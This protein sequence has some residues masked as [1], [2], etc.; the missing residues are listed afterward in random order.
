MLIVPKKHIAGL[1]E[2]GGGGCGDFGARY[3]GKSRFRRG[4][5]RISDRFE[6]GAG[7][8]VD[9]ICMHLLGGG[10]A[11]ASGIRWVKD[12]FDST[13]AAGLGFAVGVI[14]VH[15]GV[16]YL[17]L[18]RTPVFVK[19]SSAALGQRAGRKCDLL[20]VRAA[21]ET[22]QENSVAVSGESGSSAGKSPTVRYVWE[23][24]MGRL[25][26]RGYGAPTL[27]L[28]FPDPASFPW[29]VPNGL[30]GDVIVEVTI[31]EQG[32]VTETRLL[33]S[34]K[35]DIDEKVV[36]TVRN[37]RFRPATVDGVA[38]SSRQDVHFHYPG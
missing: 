30:T 24:S 37:W 25:A 31:D 35:H 5:E 3:P 13:T 15:C 34:L 17:W 8:G 29:Q 38:I 27:P 7:A 1:K 16:A 10:L 12:V 6:R 2:A 20:P 22:G 36:A 28:V 23:R 11:L 26:A 9:F 14:L 4:I 19:P 18:H 21:G 32:A 33:Q